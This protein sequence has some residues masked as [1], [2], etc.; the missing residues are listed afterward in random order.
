[1]ARYD[2]SLSSSSFHVFLTTACTVY[3]IYAIY[4]PDSAH[5]KP[6][7]HSS[8]AKSITKRRVNEVCSLPPASTPTP[9][10]N[11]SSRL[12]NIAPRTVQLKKHASEKKEV[13][14]L[15]PGPRLCAIYLRDLINFLDSTTVHSCRQLS[16]HTHS[17]ISGTGMDRLSRHQ[18]DLLSSSQDDVRAYMRYSLPLHTN[19]TV[20]SISGRH[21]TRYASRTPLLHERVAGNYVGCN[22][23][24]RVDFLPGATLSLNGPLPLQ[25]RA[26]PGGCQRAG[27]AEDPPTRVTLP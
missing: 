6:G 16:T 23:L 14:H 21:S 20:S 7:S 22:T 9:I 4:S 5:M 19:T 25:S 17:T 1:M 26:S 3:S 13:V 8:S 18:L 15:T 2:P 10:Y 12:F 27:R 24:E 11:H